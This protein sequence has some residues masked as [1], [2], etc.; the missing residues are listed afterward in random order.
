M[1]DYLPL[2]CWLLFY[3]GGGLYMWLLGEVVYLTL[4]EAAQLKTVDVQTEYIDNL[5]EIYDP[6]VRV[7]YVWLATLMRHGRELWIQPGSERLLNFGLLTSYFFWWRF[8][9]VAVGRGCLPKLVGDGTAENSWGANWIPRLFYEEYTIL[10]FDFDLCGLRHQQDAPFRGLHISTLWC[11]SY[12]LAHSRPV[13]L[14]RRAII[15]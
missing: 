6:L 2:G 1:K 4:L 3:P 15:M 12:I 5:R 11:F 13:I 9:P 10:W 8:A 14:K 7:Q